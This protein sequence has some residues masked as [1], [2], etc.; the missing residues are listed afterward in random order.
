MGFTDATAQTTTQPQVQAQPSMPISSTVKAVPR[1][2]IRDVFDRALNTD[3][4]IS[5]CVGEPSHTAA[6]HVVEAAVAAARDGKT[7]Y[8]DINGL[9][10][11]RKVAADYSRRVKKLDYDPRTEVQAV[12]GGTIGLFLAIG[13]VVAPG[14]EVIIP[15]PYFTS[16]PAAWSSIHW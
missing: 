9:P 13:T 6:P 16:Y 2:G 8:S 10:E 7:K 3:D 14:D 1:S 15:S 11:F 4:V 5:L 12:D